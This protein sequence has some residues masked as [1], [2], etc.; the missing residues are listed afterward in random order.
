MYRTGTTGARQNLVLKVVLILGEKKCY[1]C[2]N[3]VTYVSNI[4]FFRIILGPLE[5]LKNAEG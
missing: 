1:L 5:N 3:L 4:T 2:N